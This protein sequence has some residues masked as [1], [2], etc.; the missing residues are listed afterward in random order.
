MKSLEKIIAFEMIKV[1]DFTMDHFQAEIRDNLH[2]EF[3]FEK[4]RV[5]ITPELDYMIIG[6]ATDQDIHDI[7]NILAAHSGVIEKIK[8]YLMYNLR[9][10]SALLETNSYYITLNNHLLISRFLMLDDESHHFEIKL[11]TINRVELPG[12]YKDKI[13]LGRD[14]LSL[15]RI[16]RDY[17]GLKFIHDSLNEQIKKLKGRIAE[18]VPGTDRF[19]LEQEYLSDVESLV[20]EF[21]ESSQKILSQ[22]PADLTSADVETE[23]LVKVNRYFRDLKHILIEV[24][25]ALSE[26]ET[27]MF[28]K[29]LNR[30]VRYVT[31]FK[32]DI[33]NDINYIMFKINGRIS[34]YVND[35]HI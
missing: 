29:D 24:E 16:H 11:Y 32:K 3:F 13:Y 14:L 8:S 22:F 7:S 18:F 26:I 34:D 33:T 2:L 35:I 4:G 28:Q 20:K 6:D 15:R 10:Y 19:E 17:F 1:P 25:G 23:A 31:K 27:R 21:S 12:N 9:G 5:I 30:A